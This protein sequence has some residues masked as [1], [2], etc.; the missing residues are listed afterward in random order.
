MAGTMARQ[1]LRDDLRD[2]LQDAA[3]V[4]RPDGDPVFDRFLDLAALDF[5]RIRPR[6]IEGALTL[7]ADQHD[8]TA[9]AD[10]VVPLMHFWGVSERRQ[11]KPW[12]ADYPDTLPSMTM[13]EDASGNKLLRLDPA[14][15][16][17]QIAD[18]GA[19]MTYLYRAGHVVGD[20]AAQTSVSPGDRG[21]LLLRA[22]AE[23]CKE[24]AMRNSAKPVSM[25]DGLNQTPRN[26]TPAALYEALM[27]EFRAAA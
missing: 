11:R 27:R 5:H 14:P 16:A 3:S 13:V 7:V 22:Q 6:R 18:L 26:A 24:L 20:A 19:S 8:Y 9:P 25:R 2:S 21:L 4:F 15:T 10:L 1:D 12:N 23:A 17:T